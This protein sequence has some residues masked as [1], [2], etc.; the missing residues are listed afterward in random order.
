MTKENL[1]R[2]ASEWIAAWNSHNMDTIMSHYGEE[3]EFFSP[4]MQQ[5]GV[6]AEGCIRNKAQLRSYF[7]TALTK[8]PDLKFE[9]LH[10]LK[11]VHS[12]VLFYK[13]INNTHSAEYMELNAEG[14]IIRVKAHYTV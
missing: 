13:S 1:H 14:K 10:A 12:I 2:F 6:N 7:E 4:V 5:I 9:L 11:G 3:I 8:Y